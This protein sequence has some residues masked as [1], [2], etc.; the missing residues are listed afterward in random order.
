M[1]T[2]KQ[3]KWYFY[4]AIGIFLMFSPFLGFPSVIKSAIYVILG[5][6][7]VWLSIIEQE[8]IG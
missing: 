6:V 3:R 7:T 5:A 2:I 8:K 4:T 1:Q